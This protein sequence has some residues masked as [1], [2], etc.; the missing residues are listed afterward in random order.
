VQ[1]ST[2]KDENMSLRAKSN[3]Q[4]HPNTDHSNPNTYLKSSYLNHFDE[5]TQAAQQFL[6]FFDLPIFVDFV[7]LRR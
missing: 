4:Q 6:F 1:L 3:H 7:L 5:S 2:T